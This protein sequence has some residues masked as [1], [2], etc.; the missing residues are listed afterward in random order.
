MCRVSILKHYKQ[1]NAR[2]VAAKK[3]ERT[4]NNKTTCELCKHNKYILSTKIVVV[5]ILISKVRVNFEG[6]FLLCPYKMSYFRFGPIGS[7][8][9][10]IE[11]L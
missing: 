2:N 4:I 9:V 1:V 7:K 8:L 3:V 5:G 10:L 11:A 6:H